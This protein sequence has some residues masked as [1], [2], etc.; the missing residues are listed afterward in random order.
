MT[1]GEVGDLLEQE[2]HC[3]FEPSSSS[4]AQREECELGGFK[5]QKEYGCIH[6]L[7]TDGLVTYNSTPEMSSG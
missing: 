1:F 4:G 3:Y 6:R 2:V 7:L 5:G